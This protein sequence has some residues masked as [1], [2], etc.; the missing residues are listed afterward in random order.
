MTATG[1][2]VIAA[3]WA[4]SPH[5]CAFTTTRGGGVSQPPF[6]SLNLAAHVEDDPAAVEGNR[7]RVRRQYNLPGEPVWLNQVHGTDIVRAE[8]CDPGH[9]ADGS[10][11][12]R[13]GVVCAVLSADCV[14]LFLCSADGT[15]VGLFHVGWRGLVQGIVGSAS[16]LFATG[17]TAWLGP[18][19]GVDVFEIG[20]EVKS[21]IEQGVH[22]DQTCF[23]PSGD[24]KWRADLYGLVAGELRR[25]GIPCSYDTALCTY[26]DSARFFSYRRAAIC[27]RMASLIWIEP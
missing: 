5:V 7:E 22:A 19:I 14:P 23:I 8:N 20:D 16:M 11:T 27:G 24:G 1:I 26:V 2:D 25:Y 18:S 6:D 15:R 17:A 12:A 10:F 9:V 4:A 13:A 21:A 3:D